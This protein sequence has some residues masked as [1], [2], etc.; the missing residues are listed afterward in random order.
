[1][2]NLKN[3]N[4]MIQVSYRTE[5]QN[6][7]VCQS[8]LKR[9]HIVCRKHMAFSNGERMVTS[10]A[11]RC[12]RADCPNAGK[13]FRS[14]EAEKLHLRQRRFSRELIVR[15]GHRRFWEHQ[16]MYELH[17]WLTQDLH[18]QIC[19]REVTNLLADFLAMLSAAQPAKIRCKL[20]SIKNLIISVDGMQPERG[21]VFER[22]KAIEL[23]SS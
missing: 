3:S 15:I 7:P 19:E 21:R 22:K 4:R 16:T 14:V 17:D 11:H 8:K 10:W 9:N 18:I 6:C 1:M 20:N 23:D 13:D 5:Q 12:V 2:P